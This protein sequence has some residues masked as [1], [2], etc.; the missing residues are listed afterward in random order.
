MNRSPEGAL[1][2][3]LAI[4]IALAGAVLLSHWAACE[5][6]QGFCSLEESK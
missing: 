6:Y 5:Q 4:V 3:A 2:F 1:G